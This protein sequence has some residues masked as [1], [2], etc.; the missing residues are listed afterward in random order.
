MQTEY[1]TANEQPGAV[2][3]H[4]N[5]SLKEKISLAIPAQKKLSLT[6]VSAVIITLNEETILAKTLSKLWWCDEIIV[7]DSGST[8]RTIEVC[9]QYGCTVFFRSF[10]GFGEQKNFGVSKAK[11]NWILCI[12]AD[13]ILSE[14]LIDEIRAEFNKPEVPYSAFTVPRNLVFMNKAFRYGKE[15][16]S[17]LIRLFN[18][19]NGSWDGAV[20]HE[21]V[22]VEGSVKKLKSK[23]LHYSYNNYSQFLYKINLY[24]SLGSKKLLVKGS[25][26]GKAL[27]ILAIPFNFFKYYLIDRNFLNGYRGFVWALFNTFYH[28]VKHL[29]LGELKKT[30]SQ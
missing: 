10:N 29:K 7:V 16:D 15:S 8:D 21:K 26:K 5:H 18:K 9:Q 17:S 11:N 24:S 22:L 4:P 28:F 12:D 23:I 6:K 19:S 30:N 1:R 3:Q 13:E 27:V 2:S 14:E 20:V 25:H